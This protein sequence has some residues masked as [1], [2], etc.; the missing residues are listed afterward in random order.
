MKRAFFAIAT[1]LAVTPALAHHP[2][3][4]RPVETFAEGLF[5]GVGHPFLGYDHLFFIALVGIVAVFNSHRRLTPLAYVGAMLLGCLV[6]SLHRE[7]PLSGLL[8]AL[9]LLVLGGIMLSG[10]HLKSAASLVLFGLFG[11]FHGSAFGGLLA[12]QESGFGMPVLIGYLIGLGITQ[13]GIAL[14]AGWICRVGWKATNPTS[15][16]PR[17]AGALVAGMGLLFT[18]ETIGAR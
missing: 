6:A 5:S 7:L 1:S 12:Q 16:Q 8:V 3:E 15:I 18:L 14:F 13:Y 10:Y 9:S 17:L 4:G 2:L 11:L